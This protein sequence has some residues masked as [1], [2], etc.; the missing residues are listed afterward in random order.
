MR[1]RRVARAHAVTYVVT[2]ACIGCKHTDCVLVCPVD[3]FHEGEN[4][5]AIDPTGCIDC[6]LCEPEC[7]VGAIV[8]EADL[9]A[10]AQHFLAL[11]AELASAWPTLTMKRPALD[12]AAALSGAAGKLPLLIR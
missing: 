12:S 5:L 8:Y 7:P 10:D 1:R 3:C 11:N 4:F 9:P 6:G 2:E